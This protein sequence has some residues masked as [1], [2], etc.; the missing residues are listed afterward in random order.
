MNLKF[1]A[2]CQ[3]YARIPSDDDR[4]K[5][6][7]LF[8]AFGWIVNFVA[9]LCTFG[10]K[11]ENEKW[12]NDEM[13]RDENAHWMKGIFEEL[14][15]TS[16]GSSSIR[17]S[18]GHISHVCC[19]RHKFGCVHT[20]SLLCLARETTTFGCLR[21]TFFRWFRLFSAVKDDYYSSWF[22]FSSFLC[23]RPLCERVC[24]ATHA[25]TFILPFVFNAFV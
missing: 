23:F 8:S 5:Q 9:F 19:A 11:A 2:K 4:L 20:N 15:A 12:K 10:T 18:L 14:S 1:S 13:R 17:S 16:S 25:A 7:K 21:N 3:A 22:V 24:A 6:K